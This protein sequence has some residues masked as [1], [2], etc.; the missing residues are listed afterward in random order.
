MDSYLPV[1]DSRQSP[2]FHNN[3]RR[4]HDVSAIFPVR[5]YSALGVHCAFYGF[6]VVNLLGVLASWCLPETRGKTVDEIEVELR[7]K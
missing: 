4:A 7:Q 6:V 2:R 5:V 1:S 3:V